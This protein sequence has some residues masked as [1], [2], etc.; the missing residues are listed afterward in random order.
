MTRI[1]RFFVL[2]LVLVFG[3]VSLAFAGDPPA[4]APQ[5]SPTDDKDKKGGTKLF[6]NEKKDEEKKGDKGGK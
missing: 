5:P 6:E 4:P 2:G 3:A 1:V